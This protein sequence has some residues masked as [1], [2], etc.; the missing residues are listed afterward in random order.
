MSCGYCGTSNNET[1]DTNEYEHNHTYTRYGTDIKST[2][3]D[4]SEPLLGN[5]NGSGRESLFDVDLNSMESGD[6]G[7]DQDKEILSVSS[8]LSNAI[9]VTRA[10]SDDEEN[11]NEIKSSSSVNVDITMESK[12]NE[13]MDLD[14]K[15]NELSE[16]ENDDEL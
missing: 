11:Q 6:D 4:L 14:D 13:A 5:G 3:N 12:G 7:S 9:I 2:D 8:Q 15:P 16:K 1:T 10:E